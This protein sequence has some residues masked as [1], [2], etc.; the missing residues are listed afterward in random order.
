MFPEE[1]V[2]HGGLEVEPGVGVKVWST[3]KSR[4][5]NFIYRHDI[6]DARWAGG[7]IVCRMDNGRIC[8]WTDFYNYEICY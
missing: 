3:N 1:Y 8:R 7:C 5:Y 4:P 2:N 6:V